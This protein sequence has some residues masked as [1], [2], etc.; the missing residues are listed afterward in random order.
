LYGETM[1]KHSLQVHFSYYAPWKP[2]VRSL[3]STPKLFRLCWRYG[4]P[5]LSR[6]ASTPVSEISRLQLGMLHYLM[7]MLPKTECIKV[8]PT[9]RNA[10]NELPASIYQ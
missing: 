1:C 8:V 6:I 7:I 5:I 9:R 4:P 10:T 3:P 2:M